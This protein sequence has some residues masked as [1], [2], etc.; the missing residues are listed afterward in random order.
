MIRSIIAIAAAASLFAAPCATAQSYSSNSYQ[1]GLL[2]AQERALADPNPGSTLV[3][4]GCVAG[5]AS[6]YRDTRDMQHSLG[7][8]AACETLG[9]MVTDSWSN[10][11]KVGAQLFILEMRIAALRSNGY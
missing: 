3:F 8:L 11:M 1:I 5:A 10:C 9:C 7:V 2:S 6:D 4:G